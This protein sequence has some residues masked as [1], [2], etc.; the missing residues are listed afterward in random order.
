MRTKASEPFN[1]SFRI[2]F[3]RSENP[4]IN[5]FQRPL[6]P[7]SGMISKNEN[8][9]LKTF[10]GQPYSFRSTLRPAKDF[11]RIFMGT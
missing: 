5:I 9:T 7:S 6:T 2:E 4:K 8:R 3:S 10:K 11:L 1:I